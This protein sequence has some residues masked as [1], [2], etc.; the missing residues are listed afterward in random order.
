MPKA[1][2]LMLYRGILNVIERNQYDVFRKRAYVPSWQK[3]LYLPLAK[4]R[5][6]VL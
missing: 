2:A 6:E 3:L 1:T 5:A 4:V